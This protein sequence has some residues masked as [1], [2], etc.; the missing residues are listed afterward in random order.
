MLPADNLLWT[1][2]VEA[3]MSDIKS[4]EEKVLWVL[5]SPSTIAIAQ[6]SHSGWKVNTTDNN[7]Q[8]KSLYHAATTRPVVEKKAENK[9]QGS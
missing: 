4:E 6:L 2:L 7:E 9:V 8:L 3:R 1:D 5:G